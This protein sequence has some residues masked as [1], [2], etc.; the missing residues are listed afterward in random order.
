MTVKLRGELR[1][2]DE[3]AAT[4]AHAAMMAGRGENPMLREGAARDGCLL[5]FSFDASLAST[6]ADSFVASTELG[7]E[8][9]LRTANSGSVVLENEGGTVQTMTAL[10]RPF[11]DQ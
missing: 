7:I 8:Q 9:A 1:Y 3:G 5:R 4:A 6:Q 10:G 11:W 2:R